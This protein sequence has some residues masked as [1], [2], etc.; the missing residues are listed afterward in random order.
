[1]EVLGNKIVEVSH[2]ALLDGKLRS[3]A[4]VAG[5]CHNRARS[6][7]EIPIGPRLFYYTELTAKL[8]DLLIVL[9]GHIPATAALLLPGPL[10]TQGCKF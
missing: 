5:H 2:D 3:V 4:F 1:M 10:R 7:E 8:L 6:F 9:C